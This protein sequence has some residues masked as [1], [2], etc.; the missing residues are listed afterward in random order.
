LIFVYTSFDITQREN[1]VENSHWDVYMI[2]R[3]AIIGAPFKQAGEAT[4]KSR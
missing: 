4:A 1:A 2:V 3:R